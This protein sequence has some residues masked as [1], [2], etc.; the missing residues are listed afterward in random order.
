[1]M[2]KKVI[3]TAL[4]IIGFSFSFLSL[5]P[6]AN[7]FTERED[8][9]TRFKR[10]LPVL[11]LLSEPDFIKVTKPIS[12]KP[13]GQ[14]VL[15]YEIRL[16]KNWTE[17]EDKSSSNF[18]LSKKLFLELNVYYGK[19]TIAGRSRIEVQAL[20]LDSNLTAEQWYLRYILEGGYTLESFVTHSDNKIESLMV[21]MEKDYS[22]YVRTIVAFNGDKAI[23]VKYYVPIHYIQD[24]A[25]S[26]AQVL[27]SFSLRNSLPRTD[28]ETQSY[29]FLDIAELRYPED[30]KVY[31][32]P[33]RTVDRI[34]VTIVNVNKLAGHFASAR[35]SVTDGKLEVKLV[36]AAVQD[37]L[38]DEIRVYKQK[39]E[40]SGI[41]IGDKISTGGVMNYNKDINFGI[42][43]VY[44]GIDSANSLSEYEY[45]FTVMVGGNYYYFLT[46]LTP[47]R[48]ENFAVW[49]DNTQSYKNI[50]ESFRLMSG[51]FME[52]DG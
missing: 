18:T 20:D 24:Q 23:M 17:R 50:V 39:I 27:K 2:F 38:I 11:T 22:Y 10:P 1:M 40:S 21:T 30:W 43:E 51:A 5:L 15:E 6:N 32:K 31:S 47:S 41:L 37:S 4:F 28:I 34:D 12:K 26:Q 52:R 14:D 33:L 9:F 19:P 49:A 7:A 48:N 8:I 25:V 35:S 42:T 45:W 29:R 16:P 13:Y 44:I 46:L 36:A 3:F